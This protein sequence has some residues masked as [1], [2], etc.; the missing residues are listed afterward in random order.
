MTQPMRLHELIDHV[1]EEL[2]TPTR[3]DAPEELYPFLFVDEVELKV[4]VA[5]TGKLSS[6][7]QVQVY[8]LE[9]GVGGEDAREQSNEITIKLSPLVTKEEMRARLRLD[10]RLWKGIERASH[11]TVK[12]VPRAEG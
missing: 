7:G 1:K 12:E 4:N 2:L 8:V 11:A 6:S 10:E 5:V 3:A 9:A